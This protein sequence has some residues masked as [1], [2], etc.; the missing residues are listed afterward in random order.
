MPTFVF[1]KNKLK[2]DELKG[3]NTVGLE[4]KVNEHAGENPFLEGDVAVKGQV[5]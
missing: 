3:A 5:I 2:I 1:L 4:A